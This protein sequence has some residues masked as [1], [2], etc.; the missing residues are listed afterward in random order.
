MRRELICFPSK[1]SS[2]EALSVQEEGFSSKFKKV[3]TQ[4]QIRNIK[5]LYIQNRSI[6]PLMIKVYLPAILI[7]CSIAL[8]KL[9][10]N[11]EIGK[12]TRDPAQIM[13]AHPLLGFLSNIGI[14][15]WC[16]TATICYFSSWLISKK[17]ENKKI[18]SF[19]TSSAIVTG[20]L[21]FDDL[22]L[23]HDCLFPEYLKINEKFVYLSYGIICTV[24]LFKFR[25]IILQ[26]DYIFLLVAF[27]FFA[28]SICVDIAM[29][30]HMWVTG[31]LLLEDGFKFL[32]ILSWATFY[33]YT[34]FRFI[35]KY[36]K[37][38]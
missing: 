8:I 14:L 1:Y 34:S 24:Y 13:G 30:Y 11:L 12:I 38:G 4:G 9:I 10:F 35:K 3:K 2:R 21:L 37:T 5:N 22:F 26:T 16:S 27:I 33:I 19:F 15:I 25:S 18:I 7:L 28:V 17:K 36:S 32:G 6:Y 29:D 31:M 20:L 23:F